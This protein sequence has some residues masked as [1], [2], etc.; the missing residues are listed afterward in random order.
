MSLEA[1]KAPKRPI[2]VPRDKPRVDRV[3]HGNL[4][5]PGAVLHPRASQPAAR[6]PAAWERHARGPRWN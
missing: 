1:L 3:E 4:E 5:R 2:D 6:Q